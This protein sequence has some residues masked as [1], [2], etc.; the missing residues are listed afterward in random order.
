MESFSLEKSNAK[1]M[2]N[3]VG[4]VAMVIVAMLMVGKDNKHEYTLAWHVL[5]SLFHEKA[6][7]RSTEI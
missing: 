7:Q 4:M 1:H 6:R 5:S 2:W 3:R